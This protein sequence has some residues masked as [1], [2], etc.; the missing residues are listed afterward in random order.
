MGPVLLVAVGSGT[1]EASCAHIS[2]LFLDLTAISAWDPSSGAVINSHWP[3]CLLRLTP[4]LR[5]VTCR[6]KTWDILLS[7]D[8]RIQHNLCGR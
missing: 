5:T 7:F 1:M 8:A 4:G 2:K 6:V 3:V